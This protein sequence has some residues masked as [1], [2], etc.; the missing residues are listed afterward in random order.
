M[1]RI[2]AT[3][4]A[5]IFLLSFSP[6]LAAQEPKPT[7]SPVPPVQADK[8]QPKGEVDLALDELKKRH[9][10]IL[11][12]VDEQS[13]E[14]DKKITKGVIN[15]RAIELVQPTY[16]AIA[17]A[18]HASGPVS[19]LVIIDKDG[20]VMA[21]QII[22]GHP[23]LRAAALKAARASRFSPTQLEGKPVNVLGQIIYNFVAQ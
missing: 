20:K 13:A 10:G 5:T 12:M 11:T 3:L 4:A 7:P 2:S 19:V 22:D 23:L 14:S 6:I 15:G 16:P 9:E 18:A 21:A 17:R 1:N 8:D